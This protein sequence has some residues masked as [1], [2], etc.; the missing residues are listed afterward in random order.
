MTAAPFHQRP[1]SAEPLG[2]ESTLQTG[3]EQLH[4]ARALLES[5]QENLRLVRAGQRDFDEQLKRR[6]AA[7]L[8]R[9]EAV[10]AREQVVAEREAKIASATPPATPAPESAPA[11]ESVVARLTRA[12]FAIARSVLGPK[13]KSGPDQPGA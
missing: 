3:W 5:E 13:E 7:L 10:T 6:E 8:A 11:E 9:E 4:R 1:E 2:N 12:P